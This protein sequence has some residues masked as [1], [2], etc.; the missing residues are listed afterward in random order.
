MEKIEI[1]VNLVQQSL[2][3]LPEIKR[4]LFVV[5]WLINFPRLT[6]VSLMNRSRKSFFLNIEKKYIGVIYFIVI[7]HI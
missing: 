7:V 6:T 4:N 3:K 2:E 1:F 5:L